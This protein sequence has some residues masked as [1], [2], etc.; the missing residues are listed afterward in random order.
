MVTFSPFLISKSFG[1]IYP[2]FVT[3]GLENE[4]KVSL[5]FFLPEGK[6]EE[7]G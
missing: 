5:Y 2:N 3:H 7:S 4:V 1:V 6:G